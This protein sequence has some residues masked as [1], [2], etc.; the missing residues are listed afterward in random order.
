MLR[1]LVQEQAQ[2]GFLYAIPKLRPIYRFL[3]DFEMLQLSLSWFQ[4]EQCRAIKPIA[5]AERHHSFKMMAPFVS[6]AAVQTEAQADMSI[7]W[8]MLSETYKQKFM[9]PSVKEPHCERTGGILQALT[10][11]IQA[12]FSKAKFSTHIPEWHQGTGSIA[13][14]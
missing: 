13:A 1:D 6:A 2:H 8:S 7:T 5:K 9:V 11:D 3:P 10:A 14:R 4:R 12:M